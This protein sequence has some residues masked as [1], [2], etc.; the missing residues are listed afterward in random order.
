L[1][2]SL[3]LYSI[4][5]VLLTV[6]LVNITVASDLIVFNRTIGNALT[7]HVR[8]CS[9]RNSRNEIGATGVSI[10]MR[11]F[12]DFFISFSSSILRWPTSEHPRVYFL[13]NPFP[14][15]GVLELTLVFSL[16]KAFPSNK[17]LVIFSEEVFLVVFLSD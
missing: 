8:F 13:P 12:R 15:S 2:A 17:I 11:Q 5:V 10:Q 16:Y 6:S 9:K 4:A 1:S 3:V 7:A 14:L